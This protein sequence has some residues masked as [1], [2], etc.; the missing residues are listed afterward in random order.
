MRRRSALL[1]GTL[2]MLL[3][4]CT[5]GG[6][7]VEAGSSPP[8]A[9]ASAASPTSVPLDP[10][11]TSIDHPHVAVD[12][13]GGVHLIWSEDSRAGS[14]VSHIEVGSSEAEPEVIS[15]AF[16]VTFGTTPVLVRAGGQVCAF[17]DAFIDESDPSTH[18]LFMRC[19]ADG[20]WSAPELV[21]RE[22][23]TSTFD[24]A[25][26]ASGAA[27]A[28]ATTPI[29]SV[30]FEGQ[31]LS[32]EDDDPASQSILAIDVAGRYHVVWYELGQSFELNH[33]F[34]TDAGGTWSPIEALSGTQ[35]FVSDPTLIA[36][37]DGTVHL[38]YEGSLLFHRVWTSDGG[39]SEIETGP[40][41]GGAYAFALS[42]DDV[43]VAA[44][45]NISGVHL[46]TLTDGTWTPLDTVV[47]S[48][49]V[50]A[51]AISLAVGSDGSRHVAWV[52]GSDPPALR[53]AAVP[54]G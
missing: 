48:T 41:C 10:A 51:T 53:Y 34:S 12:G 17:F 44:C 30:T 33:R 31:E 36:A 8:P 43:P 4:A 49:D 38:F 42:S 37:S 19:L 1:L 5:G 50:P 35:F 7:T 22:G 29:S 32:G 46:T 45:A 14:V 11:I 27:F 15:D 39:W 18:G 26:D 9:G 16:D 40:D 3:F 25:F 24:P 20:Q 6:T 21:T 28:V 23:I 52:T 2:P 13:G 47:G 54:A